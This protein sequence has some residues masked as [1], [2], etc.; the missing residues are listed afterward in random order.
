M[1]D[2]DGANHT[3][4]N[5]F[6]YPHLLFIAIIDKFRLLNRHNNDTISICKENN[7][8]VFGTKVNALSAS[9]F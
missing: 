4:N 6:I 2:C 1:C 5:L 9:S 7:F 3:L 8:S